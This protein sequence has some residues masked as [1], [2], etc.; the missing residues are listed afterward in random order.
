MNHKSYQPLKV[1]NPKEVSSEL[2]EVYH[3]RRS[4]RFFS[5]KPVEKEVIRN[6][7]HIASSAPSGANKQPWF[8]CAISKAE[9]KRK[10]REAAEK[11][12]YQ[13]YHGRMSDSWLKDLEKFDT[14]WNKPFIENAP[15]IIVLFKQSY[16]LKKDGDKSQNYYVAES[17]GIAAGF[18]ISAIHQC[19]LVTLTHTP[20]PMDFVAKILDRPKNEKAFLLLPVGYPAENATVPVLKKKEENEFIQW[21]E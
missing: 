19:G 3:R 18:L 14:D 17:A 8:F 4:I 1:L 15:W 9:L 6:V 5:T 12:E 10:I 16:E 11:E 7:L 20:S 2:L 13:N 21:F